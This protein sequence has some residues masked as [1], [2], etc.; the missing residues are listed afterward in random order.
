MMDKIM[1]LSKVSQHINA[2]PVGAAF[3]AMAASAV[4]ILQSSQQ[5]ASTLIALVTSLAG[6]ITAIMAVRNAWRNR[7]KGNENGP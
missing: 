1:V 5:V 4:S 6:L 7:N 2:H 3:S